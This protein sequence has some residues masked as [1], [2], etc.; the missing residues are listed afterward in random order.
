MSDAVGVSVTGHSNS[1]S[2]VM[3]EP[4]VA[5]VQAGVLV[6]EV[7]SLASEGSDPGGQGDGGRI[8]PR[9][10]VDETRL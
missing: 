10:G 9:R 7:A 6:K 4:E 5:V 3:P 8:V 2:S 1:Y